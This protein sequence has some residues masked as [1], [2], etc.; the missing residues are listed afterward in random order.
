MGG[1]QAGSSELIDGVVGQIEVRI[2]APE[3]M[4]DCPAVAVICHPHPQHGGTM[5]NKVVYCLARELAAMNF[6]VAGFNFR[7]VGGSEGVYDHGAGEI[8]DL[9]AVIEQMRERFPNRPLW[10]AG[11][12]FGGYIAASAS[13]Q[14]EAQHILLV[15]PAVTREYFAVEASVN[16]P[17]VL[18]HGDQDQLIDADAA[19]RWAAEQPGPVSFEEIAGADHFFHGKLGELRQLVRD[20]ASRWLA[21]N[22]S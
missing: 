1:S 6:A 21:G 8:D 13:T 22:N 3:A 12:S 20:Y 17:G 2:D 11:F 10:L 14:S 19:H 15:A 7:G 9:V 16:V 5:D 4:D 18:I